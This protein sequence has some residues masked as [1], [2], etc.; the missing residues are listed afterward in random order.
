MT[1]GDTSMLPEFRAAWLH[2]FLDTQ[3]Q[4][5]ASRFYS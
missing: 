4:F 1:L 3:G 5:A 2:N